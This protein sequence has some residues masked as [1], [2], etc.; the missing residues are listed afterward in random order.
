MGIKIFIEGDCD[1]TIRRSR[2]RIVKASNVNLIF[3]KR[4]I[5]Q[6]EIRVESPM[7]E[8]ETAYILSG[9]DV[10]D[11]L[12]KL[13]S[14]V[15][16]SATPTKVYTVTER[17]IEYILKEREEKPNIVVDIHTHPLGIAEL[18]KEDKKT[19]RKVAEIFKEKIPGV[20]VYF[21]VH[22]FSEENFGR[23]ME[24]VAIGNRIRWRSITREHEVAIF[25]ENGKPV[26]VEI[27]SG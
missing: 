7:N 8:L 15:I 10:V 25:D 21:G 9:V 12:H 24:P 2:K 1:V 5:Y 19:M 20:R 14:D 4:V 17:K 26:V 11:M 3:L 13:S 6:M 27:W 23:R 18:S 22:A 16:V